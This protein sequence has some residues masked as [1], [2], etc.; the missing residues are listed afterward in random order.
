MKT[1]EKPR[2]KASE[3]IIVSRRTRG[4]AWAAVSSSK[5]TPVMKVMYEGTSG[6][7]QGETK[8]TSPAKN[9]ARRDTSLTWDS[10]TGALRDRKSTRLN[11]SHTVI[12][13]AVFCLKK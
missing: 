3:W 11:S 13:Y 4:P 5:E 7:T 2:M 6:S 1:R 9:A 8:E 10:N 12:S